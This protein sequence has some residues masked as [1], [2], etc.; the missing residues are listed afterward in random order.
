MEENVDEDVAIIFIFFFLEIQ[1]LVTLPF[2]LPVPREKLPKKET[3][4]NI[5]Q[6]T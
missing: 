3:Y 1:L 4:C 6:N 2:S 5:E